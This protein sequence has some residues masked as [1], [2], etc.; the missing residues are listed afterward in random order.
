[1]TPILLLRTKTVNSNAASTLCCAVLQLWHTA[2][3]RLLLFE[4]S[5]TTDGCYPAHKAPPSL[6][7]GPSPLL[8][9]V[10]VDAVLVPAANHNL[11]Q[12]HN[13][14]R[15]DVQTHRQTAAC[16]VV[17]GY[18]VLHASRCCAVH[19]HPLP[20]PPQP[21][22]TPHTTCTHNAPTPYKSTQFKPT[23]NIQHPR[24]WRVTVM[25]SYRT[26]TPLTHIT[27]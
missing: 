18:G 24:T 16:V 12:Q 5:N 26:H 9:C 11:P 6:V 7:Q 21:P 13:N 14:S 10:S 25:Y 8:C 2:P 19:P 1:M 17:S 27:R 4:R 20:T 23:A 22:H 3:L 15:R